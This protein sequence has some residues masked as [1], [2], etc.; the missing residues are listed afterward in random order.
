MGLSAHE[1]TITSR[2]NGDESSHKVK[3][4]LLAVL[5]I[6]FTFGSSVRVQDMAKGVKREVRI[7][8]TYH[9][10][11]NP[12]VQWLPDHKL[13]LCRIREP[14]GGA[15]RM[16]GS[17]TCGRGFYFVTLDPGTSKETP[18]SGLN[19][20]FPEDAYRMIGYWRLSSDGQ[21]LLWPQR[22]R[23]GS[24]WYAAR[25][26][27]TQIESWPQPPG[28]AVGAE[29]PYYAWTNDSRRWVAIVHR[30]TQ[31]D[32]ASGSLD[33]PGVVR[34]I[35]RIHEMKRYAGYPGHTMLGVTSANN[36]VAAIWQSG[37][38]EPVHLV[39]FPFDSQHHVVRS[40]YVPLPNGMLVRDI[41]LS[42]HGDRLGWVLFS[43]TNPHGQL[44][45]EL[46]VSRVDGTQFRKLA[47]VSYATLFP[48]G[49]ENH[50]KFLAW[51]QDG[52]RLSFIYKNAV[53]TVLTE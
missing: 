47:E 1:V 41:T 38:E 52:T 35:G 45:D 26:D 48:M 40:F 46:W 33:R 10:Q 21:W 34:E 4:Q 19:K 2:Y 23:E 25:L 20:Y 49:D 51:T 32:A 28:D 5:F 7:R 39:E 11:S 50:P 43:L 53:C 24:T 29:F 16:G 14:G 42:P 37:Q 31:L 36:A 22:K 30:G 13:V 3:T 15:G 44:L 17:Y 6:T 27:G 8:D 9:V 18:I 12:Y